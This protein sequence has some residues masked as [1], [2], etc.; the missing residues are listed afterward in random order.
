MVTRRNQGNTLAAAVLAVLR[1]GPTHPYAVERT[2]RQRGMQRSIKVSHGT[3]YLVFKQLTRDGLI[4]PVETRRTAGRPDR[5]VYTLTTPGSAQLLAWTREM[6]SVPA[7]EYTAFQAGLCLLAVL[8]SDEVSGLLRDRG[9]ALA[10][11]IGA[12]HRDPAHPADALVVEDEYR[13]AQL[14]L[15]RAFVE[16]LIQRIERDQAPAARARRQFHQQEDS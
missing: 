1:E 15:E 6:L 4:E 9:T 14:E 3:V 10:A 16:R 2:L 13:V 11:E 12:I 8:P 7:R 5:T